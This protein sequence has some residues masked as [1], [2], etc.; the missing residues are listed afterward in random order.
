MLHASSVFTVD[1]VA[2]AGW[3]KSK[4]LDASA[5]PAATEVWYGFYERRDVE[6]RAYASH[7]DAAG[8]GA[9]AAEQATGRSPNSNIGGGMITTQGNRVQYHAYLIAGNLVMLCQT[10]LTACQKLAAQMPV[11]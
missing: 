6:V 11:R 5:L 9:V 3:K 2:T 7:L 10:D 4:Q 8:P 1:D